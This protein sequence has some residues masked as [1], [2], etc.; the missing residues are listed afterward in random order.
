MGRIVHA[1]PGVPA[2]R[3]LPVLVL[4]ADAVL[5][6]VLFLISNFF[7][8]AVGPEE[9]DAEEGL[10]RAFFRSRA[11]RSGRPPGVWAA[12]LLA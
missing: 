6:L 4:A 10:H 12:S 9:V 7:H 5:C 11:P 3:A 1:R 8:V 2:P